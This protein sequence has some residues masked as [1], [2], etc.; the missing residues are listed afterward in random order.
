MNDPAVEVTNSMGPV[1]R[2]RWNKRL[3]WGGLAVLMA[4]FG[5]WFLYDYGINDRALRQAEAEA[6]RLDPGW[7]FHELD[8]ARAP[9]PLSPENSAPQVR[10]VHRLLPAGAA[11]TVSGLLSQLENS[12][13]VRLDEGQ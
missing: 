3:L 2:P 8:A 12:P 11:G 1:A 4:A 13:Q 10:T 5:A 9:A 6:D 7:R